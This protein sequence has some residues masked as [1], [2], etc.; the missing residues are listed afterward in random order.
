MRIELPTVEKYLSNQSGPSPGE[1][2][3]IINYSVLNKIQHVYFQKS[4]S[5]RAAFTAL[6]KIFI[7]QKFQKVTNQHSDLTGERTET[8]CCGV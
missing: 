1:R 6:I 5:S 7:N 4:P 2:M 8:L 3:N